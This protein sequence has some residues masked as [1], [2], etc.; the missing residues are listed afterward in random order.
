MLE[1][2]D[3]ET[4]YAV[5]LAVTLAIVVSFAVVA[6]AIGTVI[7]QSERKAGAEAAGTP[8][9][10]RLVGL[11]LFELDK[12]ELPADVMM[13]LG[14]TIRAAK[15]RPQASVM[16]SGYHDAS[17]DP[18]ANAEL[19]KRRAMAVREALVA[20]GIAAPRVVLARPMVTVGGADP[21]EARRVEVTL[22]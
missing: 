2:E 22:R 9:I 15:A 1:E 3:K 18:A 13:L 10:V 12:A 6:V 7:G 21:R 4:G 17:G 19:A 16:V 14:P 5:F 8:S 20:A 11:V